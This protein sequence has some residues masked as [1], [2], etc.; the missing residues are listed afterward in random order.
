VSGCAG[1]TPGTF[2]NFQFTAQHFLGFPFYRL[3]LWGFPLYRQ[4]D[5]K[6]SPSKP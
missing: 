2:G 6:S 5:E 1:N 3:A 4:L